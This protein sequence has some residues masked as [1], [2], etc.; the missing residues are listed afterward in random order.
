VT[1]ITVLTFVPDS[2]KA[3]REIARVLRP[4]GRLVIGDLGK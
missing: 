3:I 2:G 1:C 4:G